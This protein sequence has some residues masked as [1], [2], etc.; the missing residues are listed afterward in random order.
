M[1]LEK[2]LSQFQFV[3]LKSQM[4]FPGSDSHVLTA[5]AVA[6]LGTGLTVNNLELFEGIPYI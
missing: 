4:N 2:N 5:C 6:W 3:H 1:N